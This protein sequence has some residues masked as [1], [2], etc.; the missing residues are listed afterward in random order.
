M[1][2][3]SSQYNKTIPSK[4]S[5]V[6]SDNQLEYA[7]GQTIR[8]E[9]PAQIA[10]FIDPRQTYLKYK[11]QVV[12]APGVVTFS[13]KCGIH[14]I[15]D[16]V[17]VYDATQNLQLETIQNYAELAE[18]LHYYSENKSIRNK[19]GITELVEYTSRDVFQNTLADG[20]LYDNRPSRNAD[21]TMLYKGYLTGSAAT[22]SNAGKLSVKTDGTAI[23]NFT[24]LENSNECEVAQRIYS[25]VIGALSTKMFPVMLTKGLRIEI[26]TNPAAK[27]LQ[28]W[29]GNGI[30]NDTGTGHPVD[31]TS[32]LKSVKGSCFFGVQSSGNATAAPAAP[33]QFINLYTE[34]N[35]GFAQI[36]GNAAGAGQTPTQAAIDED[37]EPV[38]NQLV[39][40]MNLLVG[41][42]MWGWNNAVPPVLKDLGT[43]SAVECNAGIGGGGVVVVKV[44]L[45]AASALGGVALPLMSEFTGGAG[46]IAAGTAAAAGDELSNT[47]F[48]KVSE[49]FPNSIVPSYVIKDVELVVKTTSPPKAYVE[50]LLKESQTEAGATYDF[51]T[52]NVYR[53]NTTKNETILQMNIPALNNRAVSALCLPTQNSL[54]QKVF[55]DNLGSVSDNVTNYSYLIANKTQPTRKVPLGRLRTGQTEQIALWE[56]EKALTSSKCVVR[57]LK[58]QSQNLIIARALSRYGGVYPLEKD[59]GLQLKVEYSTTNPP[60]MDKLFITYIGGLRRLRV[61]KEGSFIES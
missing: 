21:N 2:F 56:T 12:N 57:N 37:V 53:N 15:I 60:L 42:R 39:G 35:P 25:G 8:F 31:A 54:A 58:G 11:I 1:D 32:G 40:G 5:F 38:R 4:S 33:L 7:D 43:I 16:Q 47:C 44:S 48:M 28:L 29:A 6:P 14:S 27:A 55:N 3:V 20:V 19:R 13:K 52:Y 49:F 46:R 24:G 18:K 41:K 61:S 59:G 26:D 9:I 51:M 34:K 17:R 10:P 22:Y 36:I 45:L 23:N 30:M 50:K